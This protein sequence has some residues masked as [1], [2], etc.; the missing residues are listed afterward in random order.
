MSYLKHLCKK[1][2]GVG[3][4]DKRIISLTRIFIC[5][6]TEEYNSLLDGV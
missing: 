4:N 1:D 2:F 6:D 3:L 5:V